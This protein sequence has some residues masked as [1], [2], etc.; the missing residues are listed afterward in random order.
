MLLQHAV[1]Y[2]LVLVHCADGELV[3]AARGNR[4]DGERV[5]HAEGTSSVGALEVR[6]QGAQVARLLEQLDAGIL[7]DDGV[8]GSGD[9]VRRR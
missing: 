8:G 4:R 7:D 2:R 1:T 6:R 3:G 5:A 9:L